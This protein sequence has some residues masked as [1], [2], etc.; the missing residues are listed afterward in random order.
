MRVLWNAAIRI[1]DAIELRADVYLPEREA[2]YPVILS[3][4]PYGKGYA[5]QESN[6]AA[7]EALVEGHPEILEGSSNRYQ[8]WEV[9]DPE[10][11]VP[12]GYAVVRVDSR[13]AGASPGTL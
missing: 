4:G 3:C 13:G 7:W 6:P 9:V 1:D 12:E 2:R 11:W 8:V 10:K 5:F